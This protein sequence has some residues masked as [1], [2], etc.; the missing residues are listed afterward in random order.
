MTV[1]QRRPAAPPRRTL[2]SPWI[3]AA[4]AIVVLALAAILVVP[5]LLGGNGPG[6]TGTPGSSSAPAFTASPSPGLP[7]F[8]RPTPSPSATF[9]SYVVRQGDTLNSIAKAYD[10][11]ARSIAWWNRGTYPSLD[12]E[13]ESYDPDRLEI[14]WTLVL[15]PGIEVD[16]T[17]P[18]T[19]SP[20]PGAT[21]GPTSAPQP[22]ATAGA[23]V[24]PAPGAPA[25]VIS[26]GS[27]TTPTIALT[28]DMGGRLDPAV[29]IVQWLIDHD[30]HATLFPTGKSGT[31]TAQGL[32]A[33]QL[34]SEHPELF[35]VGNHSWDHPDF[36][37]LTA[38]QMAQQLTSMEAAIAPILGTTK[39]WFRPPFGGYND[40]VRAGVGAAGWKHLVMWDV[41]MIDWR[42]VADGGPTAADMVAKL[43][44][45]GQG[46][47]IVLMHLGG[48]NTLEALPGMLTALEDLG[49]IPVTL[50]E[51]FGK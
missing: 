49:L 22:T 26:H 17:N 27:R 8:A 37:D 39:P 50:K 10:T 34:A 44:D 32:A 35:D 20:G 19:P 31:Q 16:D 1:P 25:T 45:K 47:S 48:W 7:T 3:A 6:A 5:A 33:M 38:A 21:P 30:V 18:P 36:R 23:V 24:T 29:A 9:T 46:G 11:T 40:A 4:L 28:F 43:R 2:D 13:S 14:G 15:I 41:D 42:P 12:P 51:L